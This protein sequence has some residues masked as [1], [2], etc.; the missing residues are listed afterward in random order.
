MAVQDTGRTMQSDAE[1]ESLNGRL[2]LIGWGLFL[3]MLGGAAVVPQD[4]VPQGMWSIGAGLIMLGVNAVRLYYGI[5]L[6]GFTVFVGAVSL[7]SGIGQYLG[8]ELPILP[9]LIVLIGA[10]MLLRALRR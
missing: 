6:N 3:V 2:E 5:K 7:A 1:K 4:R 8:V 10:N 9:I